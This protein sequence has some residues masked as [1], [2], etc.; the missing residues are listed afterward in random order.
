M[1]EVDGTW[2]VTWAL[3]GILFGSPLSFPQLHLTVCPATSVLC[4]AT[5]A[6]AADSFVANLDKEWNVLQ[7]FQSGKRDT[8]VLQ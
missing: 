7:I 8:S 3:V 5:I 4:V 2:S 1:A 6:C